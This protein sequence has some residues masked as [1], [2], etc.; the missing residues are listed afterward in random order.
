MQPALLYSSLMPLMDP[1]DSYARAWM[2][3]P[4]KVVIED[5]AAAHGDRQSYLGTVGDE[6]GTKASVAAVVRE[7]LLPFVD[8]QSVVLDL[9]CGGGRVARHLKPHVRLLLGADPSM[10]MLRAA[11]RY[12]APTTSTSLVRTSGSPAELPFCKSAFHLIYSFDV[13]VHFDARIIFR[14]ML[15]C[16][17]LLRRGGRL[18]IHVATT[19]TAVGLHHFHRS[20]LAGHMGGGFGA[21][22]YLSRGLLDS[23]GRLAG[24]WPLLVSV[25]SAGHF[26]C[27][28][29][30]IAVFERD[31]PETV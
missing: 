23:M 11:G 26:Y 7:F 18:V 10:Q 13:M 12:L 17:D 4:D 5:P 22:A 3:S 20:A 14:Y 30:V 31:G 15:S 8:R 24:L 27:Q 21:F 6:W 28:R 9:G 25:P 29:D 1:W 19:D 2:E 16:R